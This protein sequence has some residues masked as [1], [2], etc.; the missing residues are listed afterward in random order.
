MLQT[1]CFNL[2][3]EPRATIPLSFSFFSSH[4]IREAITDTVTYRTP[5][6]QKLCTGGESFDIEALHHIRT[7]IASTEV[8]ESSSLSH[9]FTLC[10]QRFTVR[11]L[12]SAALSGLSGTLRPN[13]K[14]SEKIYDKISKSFLSSFPPVKEK[15]NRWKLSLIKKKSGRS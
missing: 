6:K 1:L 15:K 8:Q 10:C 7:Q 11:Q 13:E 5:C 12:F 3:H 4:P 9:S 2:P 14:K